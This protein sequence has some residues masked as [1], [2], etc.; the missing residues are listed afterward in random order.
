MH[1]RIELKKL[2]FHVPDK[3]GKTKC[4]KMHIGK[5]QEACPILK[6]HNTVIENVTEDTYLGEI[7]SSDGKNSKNI[8]KRL[9]KGVGII[10]QILH[11]LE[12]VSLGHHYIEIAVLLRQA[13]FINGILTY[14]EIWYKVKLK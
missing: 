13:L 3:D 7:I 5:K 9:S 8:A 2:K 1:I 6:V 14:S 4:H 11:I 12:M 10:S